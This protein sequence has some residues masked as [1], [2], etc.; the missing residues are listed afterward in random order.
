[1]TPEILLRYI[2]FICIFLITG[3]LITEYVLLKK[4]MTRSEISRL[5]KIDAV[6]G[7]AAITL[8]T[9]GLTLWLGGF[10]KPAV[11]YNKNWIFHTKLT[12]FLIVGLLSIR[13]TGFFIKQR[14]G[15]PEETV[16]VPASILWLL[17]L[18]LLLLAIIPLL[19]GFMSR[20]VGYFGK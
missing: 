18:E 9:A 16:T 13:P 7:I 12:L 14:K 11:Y 15:N 19:A 8:I 10:G 4:I 20:G 2:H 17:K 3:T 5:A 1:M 6:Y